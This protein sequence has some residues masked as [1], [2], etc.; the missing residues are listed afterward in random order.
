[1][2]DGEEEDIIRQRGSVIN[3]IS[4]RIWPAPH[5]GVSELDT[6]WEPFMDGTQ[7]D[8]PAT[9]S[10][11]NVNWHGMSSACWESKPTARERWV[12]RQGPGADCSV[13]AGLS[14]CLE[15]NRR[16]RSRVSLVA[17][18]PTSGIADQVYS[19]EMKLY[20]HELPMADQVN[21]KMHITLSSSISTAH[22]E[23]W[24]KLFWK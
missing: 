19:W 18:V 24:V 4:T 23:G 12:V 1:M 14:V 2:A 11:S 21:L 8:I 17:G 10:S 20:F 3:G 7:P 16:W 5:D 15:H 6:E 13:V 22:G 9:A